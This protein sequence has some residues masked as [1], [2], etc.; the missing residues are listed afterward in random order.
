MSQ[1]EIRNKLFCL[2]CRQPPLA[3]RIPSPFRNADLGPKPLECLGLR[4]DIQLGTFFQIDVEES[5]ILVFLF[6]VLKVLLA[7]DEF[8]DFAVGLDAH[9][10]EEDDDGDVFGDTVLMEVH[11]TLGH[12]DVGLDFT[13]VGGTMPLT[14]GCWVGSEPCDG[15]LDDITFEIDFDDRSVLAELFMDET[16]LFRSLDNEVSTRI[17]WTFKCLCHFRVTHSVEMT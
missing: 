5:A 1:N 10:F 14:L 7:D 13:F 12:E 6:L 9:G 17:Q 11:F 4:K 8:V 3:P 16:D 2:F 15:R